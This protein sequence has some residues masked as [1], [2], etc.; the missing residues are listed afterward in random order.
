MSV[1]DLNIYG[2]CTGNACVG[3]VNQLTFLNKTYLLGN[4]PSSGQFLYSDGNAI[5]GHTLVPSDL[6]TANPNT[7][8][9]TDSAGTSNV[10]N[11]YLGNLL[12]PTFNSVT[13]TNGYGGSG[14]P[15]GQIS[16]SSIFT[17]D[18]IYLNC[19]DNGSLTLDFSTGNIKKINLFGVTN[20]TTCNVTLGSVSPGPPTHVTRT[21]QP[22]IIIV[23]QSNSDTLHN[24]TVTFAADAEQFFS[25]VKQCCIFV[26][27]HAWK[28]GYG[29]LYLFEFGRIRLRNAVF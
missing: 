13:A 19:S 1:H 21:G 25:M 14:S 12:D 27:N 17:P 11:K 5:F 9:G 6:G 15:T 16:A 29:Q 28:R 4:G 24:Q 7:F 3:G 26:N 23:K 10:I 2:R 8:I 22:L 18:S 20:G